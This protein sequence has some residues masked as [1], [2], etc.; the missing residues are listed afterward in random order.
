[1][2]RSRRHLIPTNEKLKRQRQ[3][4]RER[5]RETKR[6]RQRETDRE[7]FPSDPSPSHSFPSDH[8]PSQSTKVHRIQT[9][10]VEIC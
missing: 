3:T 9:Y 1:M 8:S 4:K 6:E 7:R 2:I 10:N 5:Q